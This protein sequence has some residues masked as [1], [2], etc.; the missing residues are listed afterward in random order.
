MTDHPDA[1]K[2]A[3][4]IGQ[5]SPMQIGP[6]TTTAR[7]SSLEHQSTTLNNHSDCVSFDEPDP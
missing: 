5:P 2:A 1:V 3:S 7:A 4:W 6:P